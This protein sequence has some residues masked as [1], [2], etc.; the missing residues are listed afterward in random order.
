MNEKMRCAIHKYVCFFFMFCFVFWNV[1]FVMFFVFN[2]YKDI[3]IFLEIAYPFL[4]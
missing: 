4:S 2:L 3:H 1:F